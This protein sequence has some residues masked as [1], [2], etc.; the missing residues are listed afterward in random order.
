MERAETEMWNQTE[1]GGHPQ[2][3]AAS[4]SSRFLPLNL[5]DFFSQSKLVFLWV[6][7]YWSQ[8]GG[9]LNGLDHIG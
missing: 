1:T 5:S 6:T 2:S 9:K 3:T 7:I 4:T 8:S